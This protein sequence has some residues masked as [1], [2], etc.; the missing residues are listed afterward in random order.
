MTTQAATPQTTGGHR[1]RRRRTR[2]L[3]ELGMVVLLTLAMGVAAFA[4][5]LYERADDWVHLHDR[6]QVDEIALVLPFAMVLLAVYA[7]RRYREAQQETA[8]AVAAEHALARTTEEY[9]S[10]FEYHPH[11][12]FAIDP[13]RRYQ[14]LNPAAEALVGHPE[15]EMLPRLFPAMP[16]HQQAQIRAA[17]DRALALDTQALEAQALE[18]SLVRE[19]GTT[20]DVDLTMVPIVVEGEAL[21]VYVLAADVTEDR[22]RRAQLARALEDAEQAAEARTLLVANVSHELRTPLAG[23]IGAVELLED[24]ELD[25]LQRRLVGVVSRNGHLL[26]RLVEDLLDVT[27]L[28]VGQLA[29]QSVPFDLREVLDQTVTHSSARAAD[30]SLAIK[31]EVDDTLPE[32]V[33]GDPLRLGQVL[34]NLLGNAVKFTESGEVGLGLTCQRHGSDRVQAV[35]RVWDTGVGIAQPDLDRVFGQ[36]EQA[37]PSSTRQHSGV[38]LGLAISRQLVELMGGDLSVASRVGAGSTFTVRLPFRL[39]TAD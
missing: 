28:S 26:L 22:R 34:T 37:D 29:V 9:R 36:F 17:F 39:A 19:D 12:V 21:G 6:F 35:L 31:V 27:R 5:D 14:R 8:A 2:S 33:L 18:V 15:E 4:F 25:D 23:V 24:G 11:A 30:K 1:T 38:G 20:R 10:L 7:W 32:R 13:Q 3:V 16:T